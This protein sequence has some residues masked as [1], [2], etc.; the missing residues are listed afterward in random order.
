[1][2][3]GTV[4]GILVFTRPIRWRKA[5]GNTLFALLGFGALVSP[6][7]GYV[8]AETG[9][10]SASGKTAFAEAWAYGVDKNIPVAYLIF[11]N[12]CAESAQKVGAKCRDNATLRDTEALV[13]RVLQDTIA[14]TVV[15]DVN[16]VIRIKHEITRAP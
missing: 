2:Y 13:P 15:P 7:L 8:H 11:Q 4:V 6:Y 9:M 12:T 1:M 10:W 5:V 16:V 14:A 3:L